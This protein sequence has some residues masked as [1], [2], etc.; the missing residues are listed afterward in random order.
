MLSKEELVESIEKLPLFEKRKIAVENGDK[1]IKDENLRAVTEKGNDKIL[2][3]VS[4]NYSLV[5]FRDI[6]LPMFDGMENIEG[7]LQYWQGRSKLSLFPVGEDYKVRNER[8]GISLKNSM[9]K[10]WA[11]K[12]NFSVLVGGK[13]I[14][15][16]PLREWKK[17]HIGEVEAQTKDFLKVIGDVKEEW[18]EIVD[19]FGRYIVTEEILEDL[20]KVFGRKIVKKFERKM[21]EQMLTLWD[22]FLIGIEDIAKRK[23]K[24][25]IHKAEKLDSVARKIID[26]AITVK[27]IGGV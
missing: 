27:L 5:Q 19:E 24:S 1:W 25:E 12:I 10:S 2:V 9:N 11:V 21:K 22:G 8:I 26:Y 23:Y 13:Y 20:V 17:I 16:L 18:K 14:V 3:T 6:F 15:A 7:D 4:K